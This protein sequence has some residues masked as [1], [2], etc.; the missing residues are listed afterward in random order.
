MLV[1]F[2][3][4]NGMPIE[5]RFTGLHFRMVV[6]DGRCDR[7]KWAI[8]RQVR[9]ANKR[10]NNTVCFPSALGNGTVHSLNNCQVNNRAGIYSYISQTN[11]LGETMNQE[12]LMVSCPI[13]N[14]KNEISE[15]IICKNRDCRE[16]LSSLGRLTEL[17][18]AFFN[19]GLRLAKEGKLQDALVKL[20]V[21]AELKRDYTKPYMIMGKIYAQ[22]GMYAGAI[23]C[24]QKVLAVTPRDEKARKAIDKVK[25]I[26][27]HSARMAEGITNVSSDTTLELNMNHPLESSSKRLFFSIGVAIPF[28]ILIICLSALLWKV[29]DSQ[30]QQ[31]SVLQDHLAIIEEKADSD[32][33]RLS[34][35]IQAIQSLVLQ[36][37]RSMENSAAAIQEKFAATKATDD[38]LPSQLVIGTGVVPPVNSQEKL[39]IETMPKIEGSP[40]TVHGTLP[41]TK[42]TV[43]VKSD[44]FEYIVAKGDTLWTIAQWFLSSPEKWQELLKANGDNL[45]FG[46]QKLSIGQKII[47]PKN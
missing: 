44:R 24:W 16:D 35:E 18:Y 28:G 43:D 21:A 34:C 26:M 19:D 11:R 39:Q 40:A 29:F 3:Q 7:D 10:R 27:D 36:S 5:L 41:E 46:P 42:S 31:I 25:E 9:C 14:S 47:I 38:R 32:M 4:G 17:P 15:E 12:T 1:F 6:R 33:K 2:N 37:T 20:A 23:E 30:H 45:P 8:A 13:D 22:K